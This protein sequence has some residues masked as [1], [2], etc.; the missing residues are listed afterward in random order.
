MIGDLEAL[1][2]RA[3]DVDAIAARYR[4]FVEEFRDMRPGPGDETLLAL[5]QLVH[6]R[7]RIPI[8]DPGLPAALLPTDWA[9]DVAERVWNSL[10]GLWSRRASARW[11]EIRDSQ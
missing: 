3:W 2:R 6:Q 9:G 4:S 11:C 7:R 5:L 8:F 10:Q 1:I